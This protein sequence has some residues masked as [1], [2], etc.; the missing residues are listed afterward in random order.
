MIL[1][2]VLVITASDAAKDLS[3]VEAHVQIRVNK[4]SFGQ[5]PTT[6]MQ[7]EV[8][9]A[10]GPNG[11]VTIVR[12]S[13]AFE[14]LFLPVVDFS[15]TVPD[16][17]LARAVLFTGLE[18]PYE[19]DVDVGQPFELDLAVSSRLLSTPGGTG[20]AAVF[21]LPQEGL[22]SILQRIKK[23][24]RGQRLSNVIAQQVDT[25]GAVGG[26]HQPGDEVNIMVNHQGE[27]SVAAEDE[28]S[29]ED[30]FADET[31][32][33]ADNNDFGA[34]VSEE[35]YCT[36]G[37]PARYLYQRVE[38]LAIGARQALQ[39]GETNTTALTPRGGTI[40]F[41]L[42]NE[43]AQLLASVSPEDVYLTLL[44]DSYVVE[45]LP[46]L[47]AELMANRTP[48][49]ISGCGTPY[50]P[51]GFIEGDSAVVGETT[52]AFTDFIRGHCAPIWDEDG[53]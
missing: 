46:A 2:G 32:G 44:P 52:D 20:A 39:A 5:L 19:Y 41:L 30:L 12:A 45:P 33:P 18:L 24:D 49:E 1:S 3:G 51:D 15:G 9:L 26:Y 4:L 23:D 29:V 47:T 8:T 7:G 38:I 34:V 53:E 36:Y 48:A 43:A 31:A 35:E 17:P 11:S 37:Q 16:L 25:T 40:T 28:P 21:G 22:S 27:C 13:G 50:G 42:P 14:G 6:L 10:G